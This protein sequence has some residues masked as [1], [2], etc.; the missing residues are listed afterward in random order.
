MLCHVLIILSNWREI[1]FYHSDTLKNCFFTNC[2]FYCVIF[3]LKKKSLKN[4]QPVSLVDGALEKHV[5]DH[6]AK[7]KRFKGITISVRGN[8]FRKKKTQISVGFYVVL[9]RQDF[10]CNYFYVNRCRFSQK[11]TAYRKMFFSWTTRWN[12]RKTKEKLDWGCFSLKP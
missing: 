9:Q 12:Q 7:N 3:R 1:I 2:N 4:F 5:H 6:S 10:T 11:V 8:P